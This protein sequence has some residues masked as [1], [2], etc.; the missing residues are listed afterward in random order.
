MPTG[1]ICGLDPTVSDSTGTVRPTAS[2][3]RWTVVLWCDRQ[4]A[5]LSGFDRWPVVGDCFEVDGEVWR[6]VDASRSYLAE[7]EASKPSRNTGHVSS[8]TA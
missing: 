7:R 5:I 3:G 2:E 6:V 4:P 8:Q 1:E